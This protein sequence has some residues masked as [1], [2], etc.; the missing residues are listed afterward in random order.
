MKFINFCF[1]QNPWITKW[2]SFDKKNLLICSVLI[3]LQSCRAPLAMKNYVFRKMY[4]KFN[5]III[6]H[7]VF[8]IPLYIHKFYNIC[9][10]FWILYNLLCCLP[11][12][13]FMKLKTLT[14]L[15][16]FLLFYTC[17][18][19]LSCNKSFTL[20][21]ILLNQSYFL[22][23]INIIEARRSNQNVG[24]YGHRVRQIFFKIL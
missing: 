6:N 17:S 23:S 8:E 22:L 21:T 4:L 24:F 3:L 5:V 20:T 9:F 10:I 15:F 7:D 11:M 2:W 1:L 12:P 19:C 16:S 13:N 14:L 18:G